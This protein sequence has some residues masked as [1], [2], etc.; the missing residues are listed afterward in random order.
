MLSRHFFP[1]HRRVTPALHSHTIPTSSLR[2]GQGNGHRSS[3]CSGFHTEINRRAE[4]TRALDYET[5][6][7]RGKVGVRSTEGAPSDGAVNLQPRRR[8]DPRSWPA[9]LPPDSRRSYLAASF[10]ITI[11]THACVCRHRPERNANNP[12]VDAWCSHGKHANLLLLLSARGG[13]WLLSK[14]RITSRTGVWPGLTVRAKVPP[15]KKK[16]LL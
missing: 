4:E 5:V 6:Q 7:L 10:K 9:A 16:Q 15:P 2:S 8:H 11:I 12:R 14:V 1:D 3:S 13:K